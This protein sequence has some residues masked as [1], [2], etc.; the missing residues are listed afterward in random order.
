[1]K[2]SAE[3]IAFVREAL[4]LST[5]AEVGLVPLG[6]RGSDRSYFRVERDGAESCILVRYDPKRTENTYF[7]EI[8]LFLRDIHI[9]VPAIIRHD[10]AACLVL[11]ED[12]GEIDLWSLRT[13][14][15]E[16]RSILYHE[17]L[18]AVD[19]LHIFPV[20][21][22]PSGRVRL[23]EPFSRELYQW[24]RGY[25]KEHFVEGLC[26]MRLEPSFDR[27]LEEELSALA[28]RLCA[29]PVCLVH[30]DLQSQNV[31]V[32]DEKPFLIDFQGMR[33]GSLFYDLGSLSLR[34]L[35]PFLGNRA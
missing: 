3:L 13:R 15:R 5:S 31:M 4:G 11:M 16:I 24:E 34:S 35:C 12:L 19:R 7:A 26:G 14:P 17:T 27:A 33:F 25:F 20:E 10:P 2:G 8:A 1:M 9:P 18:V 28:G 21:R 23:M 30:R 32:R 6:G 29:T 22:F